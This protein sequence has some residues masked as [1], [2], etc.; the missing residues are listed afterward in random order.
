MTVL[1]SRW[2]HLHFT[3]RYVFLCDVT[4]HLTD[5]AFHCFAKVYQKYTENGK[6]KRILNKNLKSIIK[7]LERPI[8]NALIRNVEY[9]KQ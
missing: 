9:F 8:Y 7:R 6:K 4:S 5:E 2:Q 3:R 1:A